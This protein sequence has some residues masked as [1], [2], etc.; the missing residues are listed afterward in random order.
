MGEFS[1]SLNNITAKINNS[2]EDTVK[3]A[4]FE[5]T[6]NII[7]KSP[8]DSGRFR[9]NWQ[10]SFNNPID[11]VL[12]TLDKSGDETVSKVGSEI[13]TNKVPM[14]YWINNNL[15]YAEKLEYGWSKQAPQGFVRQNILRINQLIKKA[16]KW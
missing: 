16:I 2:V 9:G 13:N 6:K 7:Y 4:V 12:D 1:L 15:P 5:L 3:G 11:S 14:A 10:V 8:V